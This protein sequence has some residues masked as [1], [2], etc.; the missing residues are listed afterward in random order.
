VSYS[1]RV[2]TSEDIEAVTGF[3]TD[4]FSWGDYVPRELEAW[5]S[6]ERGLVMVAVDDSGTAVAVSRTVMLSNQ[7]AWLH[8]ARVHPSHR[9]RGLGRMLNDAGCEWASG[10]GARIARLMV[11][12]W[13]EA[14]QAQVATLGYR[15]ASSWMSA[16]VEVGSEVLPSTNGG[17]RVPGEERLTPGRAAEADVAW[18]S[19]NLSELARA[20]RE[21]FP[22]GWH[23]RRMRPEDLS[24]AATRRELWHCPSGWVIA[25]ND[26]NGQLSLPWL[27]TTDIDASRLIRAVIDLADGTRSDRIHI[28]APRL[29]WLE[30]AL[31][32]AGFAITPSSVFA[33]N[34]G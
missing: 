19:W 14:A 33:R 4:T 2:A 28:L 6:D 23:F 22:V 7:E 31:E 11:E 34:L 26:E 27:S 30:Q 15:L 17:R 20:G 24:A 32:R 5:L 13:N 3:T 29:G 16:V 21:L 18:M 9:R 10:R 25:V 1:L 8:A 12:D